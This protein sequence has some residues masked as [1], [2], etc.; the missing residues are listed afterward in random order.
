MDYCLRGKT[1]A[2]IVL[3]RKGA[4]HRDKLRL[5]APDEWAARFRA[6]LETLENDER[7]GNL[8]RT[9][10]VVQFSDLL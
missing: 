1:S 8:L 3:K 9:I 5:R 7:P 10:L 6:G 4:Y 2:R